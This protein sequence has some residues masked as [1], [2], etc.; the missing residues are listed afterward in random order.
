[1]LAVIMLPEILALL[2]LVFVCARAFFLF[3]KR[4]REE[5]AR[6]MTI[7]LIY[8]SRALEKPKVNYSLVGSGGGGSFYS[9]SPLVEGKEIDR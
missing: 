9:R 4:R 7:R 6:R 8:G 1:M 2:A 5:K 3:R